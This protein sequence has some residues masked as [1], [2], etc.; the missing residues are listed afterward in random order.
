MCVD[1]IQYVYVL[2]DKLLRKEIKNKHNIAIE[3]RE[4]HTFVVTPILL[5]IQCYLVNKNMNVQ[6]KSQISLIFGPILTFCW[7]F[8]WP[9]VDR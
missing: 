7:Q 2:V 1:D 5:H 3:K 4:I 9:D 6:I 8:C